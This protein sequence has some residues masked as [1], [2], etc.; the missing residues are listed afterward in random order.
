MP[1]PPNPNITLKFYGL[2][3]IRFNRREE[4][5]EIGFH[6]TAPGHSLRIAITANSQG[7]SQIV[8]TICFQPEQLRHLRNVWLTVERPLLPQ[9]AG[10]PYQNSSDPTVLP[11]NYDKQDIR[12]LLDLEQDIYGQSLYFDESV[13]RPRLFVRNALFYTDTYTVGSDY[14]LVDEGSPNNYLEVG[15][16]AEVVG[17]AMYCDPN[18]SIR[19]SAGEEENE[20]VRFN[21]GQLA[22]DSYDVCFDN[23]DTSDKPTYCKIATSPRNGGLDAPVKSGDLGTGHCENYSEHFENYYR[24]FAIPQGLPHYCL[25]GGAPYPL[26]EQANSANK[27]ASSGLTS[28]PCNPVGGGGLGGN[29]G[30]GG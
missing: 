2:S 14:Y 19:L 23:S 1:I 24:T 22:G 7:Q 4:Y 8:Q 10:C 12:W 3:V 17:A 9:N 29:S 21:F 5:C 11:H 28:P 20:L 25:A 30:N 16:I 6:N 18:S 13:L 26:S 15:P 27:Q